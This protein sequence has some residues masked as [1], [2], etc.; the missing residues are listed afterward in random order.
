MEH[1]RRNTVKRL[2]A[3]AVLSLSVIAG[4]KEPTTQVVLLR[5][6]LGDAVLTPRNL[7]TVI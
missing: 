7:T 4:S 1:A 3:A 5:N 2:L 6:L